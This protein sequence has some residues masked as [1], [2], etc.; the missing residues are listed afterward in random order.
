TSLTEEVNTTNI[1]DLT[2]HPS[3]A[4]LIGQK[5]VGTKIHWSWSGYANEPKVWFP[6]EIELIF[7]SS[8]QV[9]LCA[10]ELRKCALTFQQDSIAVV[11]GDLS[12]RRYGIG[13]CRGG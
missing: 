7:E 5:I 1:E 3:W 8:Y 10:S 9:F 12:A 11:F 2:N 4:S 13:P 6:Q